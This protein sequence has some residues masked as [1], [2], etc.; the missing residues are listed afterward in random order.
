MNRNNSRTSALAVLTLASLLAACGGGG[1][2]GATPPAPPPAPAPPPPPAFVPMADVN[3]A[4]TGTLQGGAAE[5]HCRGFRPR[6][7]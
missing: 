7:R 2:G 6:L 5:R 4:F 3:R 1:G